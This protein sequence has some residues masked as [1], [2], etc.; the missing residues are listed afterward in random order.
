LRWQQGIAATAQVLE[1]CDS[2]VHVMDREA[3][4]Y[5]IFAQIQQLQHGFVVRLRNDRRAR[6]T[7]DEEYDEWSSLG[8]IAIEMR[9]RF[10]RDVP[11]SKR[12][13]KRAPASLKTH[14]PRSDRCASLQFGVAQVE[15]S[16]PRWA[17]DVP[18]PSTLSLN[19][20]RVWEPH[21]PAG[22]QAVEWLLLTNEP[23]E[24]PEEVGRI[25]DLYRSR[26]MI[27]D[28]FKALKTGCSLE[29]RELESRHALLN[30][31][32]IFLPIATH[33]LWIRTCARDAADMPATE[34][35]TPFQLTALRHRAYR[36]IPDQPTARDALWALAGIGGHIA[37]NG[38]P[39]WQ[40][41]GRAFET[42]LAFF[43]GW[44]VATLA[45]ARA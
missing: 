9:G 37:N 42:F 17:L 14:P 16:R 23:C 18:V 15:I 40:V 21:P 39:G 33:L 36:R 35:F 1:G 43:Y 22:E 8:K 25:V 45:A 30:T 12:G 20:V 11:L 6:R 4:S 32:A 41:L 10:Q 24:T 29:K 31:L 28:F 34:V 3:D 27:E 5:V 13:A 38:W 2:I 19:L 7:D 26:W 44:K